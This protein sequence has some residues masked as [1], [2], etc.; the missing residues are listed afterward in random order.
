MADILQIIQCIYWNEN[1]RIPNQISLKYF[2]GGLIDYAST[3]LPDGTLTWT[4]G[5]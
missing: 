5:D 2:L 4:N 1:V 3:L